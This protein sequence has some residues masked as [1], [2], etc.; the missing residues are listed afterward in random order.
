MSQFHVAAAR[1]ETEASNAEYLL[2]G[3]HTHSLYKSSYDNL[4]TTLILFVEAWNTWMPSSL[5]DPLDLEAHKQAVLLN[6]R[7][8]HL[9]YK[10]K[11]R[12][13]S[14]KGQSYSQQ[15]SYKLPHLQLPEFSGIAT[16]WTNYWSLFKV[17]VHDKNEIESVV[18]F[19]FLLSSLKGEPLSIVKS[20]PISEANYAIA[21]KLLTEKYSNNTRL[22][23]TLLIQLQNLAE[24][25]YTQPEIQS[26]RISY[27]TILGQ[28]KQLQTVIDE[29]ILVNMLYQK[30]N[31]ATR[32]FVQMKLQ[33]LDFSFKE[34]DDT[35]KYLCEHLERESLFDKKPENKASIKHVAQVT[36]RQALSKPTKI[37]N[38]QL[39]SQEHKVHL[40]PSYPTIESK[41]DRVYELKLCRNCLRPNHRANDCP[42][43]FCCRFCNRLHHS[44]LCQSQSVQNPMPQTNSSSQQFSSNQGRSN[45]NSQY[46]KPTSQARPNTNQQSK[47]PCPTQGQSAVVTM[48]TTKNKLSATAIP[49][50]MISV[51]GPNGWYTVRGFFDTA[52][53]RSF[54]ASPLAD[55]LGLQPIDRINLGLNVF[56]HDLQYIPCPLVRC[57]VQLGDTKISMKLLAHDKVDTEVKTPGLRSITKQ[58]YQQGLK[59]ADNNIRSDT[60]SDIQVVIGTDYFCKFV[61]GLRTYLGMNAFVSSGGIMPFGPLPK[62][63]SKYDS[64]VVHATTNVQY[65]LC[66]RVSV[67]EDDTINKLWEFDQVGLQTESLTPSEASAKNL[68]TT[69]IERVEGHYQVM[70]PFHSKDRPSSN[71]MCAKAQLDSIF[72]HK[73][74]K[75]SVLK[76][77][78]DDVFS[79]YV[80]LNFIEQ[81]PLD[82]Q[83]GHYLPHHPVIKDSVTT[84]V[85]AVFN[86]SSSSKTG[87]SLNSCL[88]TGPSLVSLLYDQLLLFRKD[89]FA[90]LADISKAFH[91]VL[92]HPS[93]R[94]YLKFLYYC[95]GKLVCYQFKV[96]PFGTTCSPYLLQQV[97]Y[98]HISNTPPDVDYSLFHKFYVDN[99]AIT[100]CSESQLIEDRPKVEQCLMSAQMPLQSWTS[101]SQRFREVYDVAEPEIQ[102]VLGIAWN[103]SN[104]TLFV[105]IPDVC[106]KFLEKTSI[107]RR[108]LLSLVASF[109]DPLGL[110]APVVSALRIILQIAWAETSGWDQQLSSGTFSDVKVILSE[111]SDFHC[112]FPRFVITHTCHLHV[113]SDASQKAYGTVAYAVYYNHDSF[114]LTSKCKVTPIKSKFSIAKL[115][116]AALTLSSRLTKHICSLYQFSSITL[117]CDSQ[118][119]IAWVNNPTKSKE[120]FVANR[121]REIH[122]SNFTVRYVP[123]KDNSADLLS[124]GTTPHKLKDA[125]LWTQG[126]SW[127]PHPNLH[128]NVVI[129][130]TDL[131]VVTVLVNFA[132]PYVPLFD[133]DHFSQ[134]S[135]L[136]NSIQKA[137]SFIQKI[138]STTRFSNVSG[139]DLLISQEQNLNAQAIIEHFLSGKTLDP[140]SKNFI[141]QLNLRFDPVKKQLYTQTRIQLNNSVKTTIF[142][143]KQSRLV[144]LIL[145]DLHENNLHCPFPTLLSLYQ[146]QFTTP[147]IR[148]VS[149]SFTRKCV[150]CRLSKARCEGRPPLPPL[151]LPRTELIRPF[152]H[153]A[154]DHTG[155]YNIQTQDGTSRWY[156]AV[157]VCLSTR[158]VWLDVVNDLTAV[159]VQNTL[160][161]LFARHGIPAVIYSDNHRSFVAIDNFEN[162]IEVFSQQ[163][164]FNWRFQT[165]KA[166]W[167]GGHFERLVGIT[168]LALSTSLRR[169]RITADDFQTIVKEA[170]VVVNQRPLGYIEDA[171]EFECLTPNKL[172]CG[173][174]VILSPLTALPEDDEWREAS[175]DSLKRSYN[176]I[177][178]SVQHFSKCFMKQYLCQLRVKARG[179]RNTN[180]WTP[181]VGQVVLI[182]NSSHRFLWPLAKVTEVF[183]GPD[184][185]IRTVRVRT[186]NDSLLRDPSLLLPLELDS[187]GEVNQP[188]G[189]RP[190]DPDLQAEAVATAD[191]I[192]PQRD[193]SSNMESPPDSPPPSGNA[194]ELVPPEEETSVRPRRRAAK[195]QRRNL[196]SLIETDQ[197]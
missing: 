11:E 46:T 25:S 103:T 98:T 127:L 91:R 7:A 93:H 132:Q 73:F 193:D 22:K 152:L 40:C 83:D 58:M 140:Q 96:V 45:G 164:R 49:T 160:R 95:N 14:L 6:Q 100:S 2:Q 53:Q 189:D 197:I 69:S 67:T 109:F 136:L 177:I 102:N 138:C 141:L 139:L 61:I 20:L 163:R 176:F 19:N 41:S 130:E 113:F 159:G 74:Q 87:L 175:H 117:W 168:K 190:G 150:R 115:E 188:S 62:W 32:N 165:P 158:A 4:S 149:K 121:A 29:T 116:L 8:T 12:L 81:V 154:I 18:K 153:V 108:E 146:D 60:L 92:V 82:P 88:Y 137:I 3:T 111:F 84:P 66:A 187:P 54:I 64:S 24:P 195:I 38:C 178:Q 107:S 43:Q 105:K 183:S 28:Y 120:V 172:M 59:L 37:T 112:T 157:C 17:I 182:S 75:D 134:L 94:K 185:H 192:Q 180:S 9:T 68:V 44:T 63:T 131:P 57:T 50:A 194:T 171:A 21:I 55:S 13:E 70:L 85:R 166:P 174:P 89:Q 181:K 184:G 170:E 145:K 162:E 126:P 79:K 148:T 125:V 77:Q 34:L 10:L 76:A 97:L 65:A 52:S 114:L 186:E 72:N 51:R 80:D 119:A 147:N 151:P 196:Q 33:K 104:D 23:D 155:A 36:V 179:W 128:P 56:G 191:V 16:E 99:L 86:A 5:V 142:I 39:C 42:S 27:A 124:R 71:F 1:V 35:L 167:K 78:Y 31:K 122:D 123:S 156:I 101:N 90:M 118:V 173:R 26:F 144:Y 47:Q 161:R 133:L 169:K 30:L 15:L 106:G 110:I 48:V 143:P 135:K 129:N